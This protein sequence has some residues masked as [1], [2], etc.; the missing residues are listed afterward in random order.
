MSDKLDS[1]LAKMRE[2]SGWYQEVKQKRRGRRWWNPRLWVDV[3]FPYT[4]FREMLKRVQDREK[5]SGE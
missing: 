1:T 4:S 5:E 3:I 2:A